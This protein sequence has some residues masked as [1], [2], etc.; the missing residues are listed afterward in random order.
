MTT[1][2]LLAPTR[3]RETDEKKTD[4]YK[5][6]DFAS[7][8]SAWKNQGGDARGYQ[9]LAR[10]SKGAEAVAV[11]KVRRDICVYKMMICLPPQGTPPPTQQ[12]AR[13]TA[14]PAH[15]Q[16]CRHTALPPG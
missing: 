7:A 14:H 16:H 13:P 1:L 3:K 2:G 11:G 6:K 5:A 4:E 12:P 15:S 8:I 9:M 10:K